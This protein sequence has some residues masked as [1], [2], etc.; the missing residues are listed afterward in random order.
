VLIL[1]DLTSPKVL[2][3]ARVDG[4]LVDARQVGAIARV[5]VRSSP[6]LDYPDMPNAAPAERLSAN[7]AAVDAAGIE[8]WAPRMEVTSAGRTS[9]S[10]VPCEAIS[11]PASYSGT[12]L[13][14]VLTFDV[15]AGVLTDG[16][17][18][19]IVA[20]G[21]TV[22]GTG[23]SLYVA[24]N[25]AW[26][27]VQLDDSGKPQPVEPT[28]EIYKFNT[29]APGRPTFV[30]GGSVPGHLINQY[31]MSEWNDKLRVATTTD[32]DGR[33]ADHL[34]VGRLRAGPGRGTR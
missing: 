2:S 11:R 25:Q 29:S 6:H 3:R 10:Q 28:T 15:T 26:R 31:A 22:Y 24:S 21:D 32:A 19:S 16:I 1:V 23:P 8:A 30:A 7:Q 4:S 17:P 5:V 12:N 13:L 34:P 27:A 14:T 9:R 33:G 18:V 20:D